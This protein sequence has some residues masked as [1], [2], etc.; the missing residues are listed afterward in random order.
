[1]TTT[2][3]GL[4][5]PTV[6]GDSDAW[7]GYLNTDLN[8]IDARL[9]KVIFSAYMSSTQS[10][11]N[12]TP[13]KVQFNAEEYDVGSYYDSATNYRFT[14]LVAG[15][16]QISGRIQF[17]SGASGSAEIDLYKNGSEY[18]RGA[19]LPFPSGGSTMMPNISAVVYLNGSTDY[20]ELYAAQ[21]S[22][23]SL[24]TQGTTNNINYFQAAIIFPA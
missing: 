20:I 16:Y 13:T 17:A 6:G 7:G 1:M 15:Y 12:N 3:L 19:N 2:N 4:T 24:S 5:L 14:P 10:F 11:T 18:K 9:P 23:G 21:N 8:L 22:G